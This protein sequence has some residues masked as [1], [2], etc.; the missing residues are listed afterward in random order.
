MVAAN[1]RDIEGVY[2]SRFGDCYFVNL[3]GEINPERIR[4]HSILQNVPQD[5][6]SE[7]VKRLQI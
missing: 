6:L 5:V 2:G 1:I 4:K 7:K 3:N